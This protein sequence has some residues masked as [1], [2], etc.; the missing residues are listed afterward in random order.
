MV[1]DDDVNILDGS[2][3]EKA[4]VVLASKEIGLKVNGDKTKFMVTTRDQNAGWSHNI[5]IENT[6]FK[7]VE[8]LTYLGKILTN[9]NSVQEENKTRLNSE[10]ACY[11]QCTIFWL[12]FF[13]P[14]YKDMYIY[15]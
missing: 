2:V 4:E 15:D 11:I 8:E 12:R 9:E 10:N 5:E 13:Y 7:M 3:K 14:N 1:Y 6:S